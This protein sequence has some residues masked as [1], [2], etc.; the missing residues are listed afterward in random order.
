MDRYNEMKTLARVVDTGS[1]SAAARQ[2][3]VGQPAVSKTIAQ[4]EDRLG[5]RLLTRSTRGLTPTE[6]CL[7]YLDHARRALS[8]TD[9][10][11][12]AAR[13]EGRG[14]EGVLRISAPTSFARLHVIPHLADFLATHPA[15]GIDMLLDDRRVDLIEEGADLSLRIG[16]LP[17]SAASARRIG[18][19]DRLVVATPAYFERCG[20]PAAPADLTVHQAVI[21]TVS[22]TATWQ[23]KRGSEQISLTV[24]GR[25]RVSG[26]EGVR[27]AILADL[28]L[29]IASRWLFDAEL[30]TGAVVATLGDWHLP[31]VDL[32][33]VYPSGRLASAKARAFA[34]FLEQRQIGWSGAKDVDEGRSQ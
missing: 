1:F 16:D 34:A 19:S 10:A 5:V 11:D 3:R 28:G 6:A 33:A 24:S 12:Q 31:P 25:L 20:M 30:A 9:E 8:E 26:A 17:D 2:L 23:F 18:R 29:T 7:R 22:R 14:L 15:L 21:Y 4:L 27:A 32:W 13:S